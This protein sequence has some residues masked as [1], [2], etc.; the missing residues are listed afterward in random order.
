M[1][2][3]YIYTP[4]V[5]EKVGE[6][7]GAHYFTIGQRKGINVGG[8]VEPLF[9][10]DTD[11]KT[12]TIYVGQGTNHKGLFRP[13]LKVP[14]KDIHWIRDDLRLN[15]GETLNVKSR[16][17][18]RQPLEQATLHQKEDGMY[19]IFERD[20]RGIASGQFV[21]WYSDDELLG[22]GIIS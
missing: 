14:N 15:T 1:S 19:I 8:K 7:N 11:T 4:E 6:H 20:Q 16:I 2:R 5:G 22:S 18:Y 13:A 10:I 12:N 21:A 17:R 9:V 3:D